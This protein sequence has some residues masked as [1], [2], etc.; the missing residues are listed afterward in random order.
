ME[1]KQTFLDGEADAWYERNKVALENRK[2]DIVVSTLSDLSFNFK[3]IL[4]IGCSNAWRLEFLSKT[5]PQAQCYGIEPSEKA[6]NEGKETYPN[7]HLKQ[8]TADLLEFADQSFDLVIFGFCLYL[9]DR[10][11]IFKIV[12]EADR[13]LR[14]KGLLVIFDFC[15]SV[16]Y[17]NIYSQKEGVF[18][19]KMNYANLFLANP[20]YSLFKHELYAHSD[21]RSLM[22]NPDDRIGISVLYKN[23]NDSWVINPY[24]SNQESK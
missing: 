17:K 19:Y 7:L 11:D 1:Q 3:N 2:S 6:I 22:I 8:G 5:Y 13:V 18:S 20:A 23:T 9:C 24:K 10:K 15:P 4:E 21:D 12:A 16:P 14:E